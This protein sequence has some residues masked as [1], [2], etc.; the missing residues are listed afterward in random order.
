MF[1][2]NIYI[3][4]LLSP[5]FGNCVQHMYIRIVVVSPIFY[6]FISIPAMNRH[7]ITY[8]L[9]NKAIYYAPKNHLKH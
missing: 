3:L 5:C 6:V 4:H 9:R 8:I 2:I 1:L 7:C